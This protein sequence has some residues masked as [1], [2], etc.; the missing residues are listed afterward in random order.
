MQLHIW[1]FL[2]QIGFSSN[3]NVENSCQEFH[4]RHFGDIDV[5]LESLNSEVG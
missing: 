1:S 5:P 2:A 4:D 3:R